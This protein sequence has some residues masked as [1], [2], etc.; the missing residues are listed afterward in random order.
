M[1]T[2]VEHRYRPEGSARALFSCRSP[3][4]VLSGAA[5]TGKSRACLEKLHAMCLANP[6]M[7]GLIVRKTAVSLTSTAMVTYREIVAR[8][9]LESG[10]VKFYHGSR[11]E[12][13]SYRYGNGSTITVGGMDKASRIMSSEYDVIYVQEA[14]ELTLDDWEALTTRLR[15]GKVSFQQ[16][17]AD[18][19]PGPPH[20]WLKRRADS[21]PL[22][23]VYCQH[24][25]NPRLYDH[26]TRLWTEEGQIY[27]DRLDALT[28]VRKQRLR[29]GRW[30][31][32]E[33]LVYDTFDPAVH[34]WKPLAL[35]PKSWTRYL[36]VDFGYTNPFCCQ[37]WAQDP[38]GRLFLYREIY[39]TRRLVEDH[40]K[41]INYLIKRGD[42]HQSDTE[43]TAIICDHDAEDR[44][45]L[46][47]HLDRPTVAANKNVSEGIQAVM[48]RFK[49]AGDGR[50]RM[51]LCRDALVERDPELE[52]AHKPTCTNEEIVEYIWDPASMRSA[53]S[54]T[55][56]E[57][58]LKQND[59]GAD[60]ARYLCAYVDL[61]GAPRVRFI[62]Y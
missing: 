17:M 54:E 16:L 37:F 35:P 36:C 53:G 5:G 60:C 57:H 55:S 49:I 11:T 1:T 15:N 9:A 50:P 13:A 3:E 22:E 62:R 44:A 26:A 21:G 56:S 30:A 33:G 14:T 8:E 61:Q 39:Y 4:V 25:D 27:L 45:T 29:H 7:R 24:E 18:C 6:H 20:H 58:P 41:Q 31:A 19:N 42:G 38:D 32:A 48:E 52:A 51:Y 59:H 43:P 10:E 47:R 12:A 34:F 28:G 23:M 2:A 40:A 46:E